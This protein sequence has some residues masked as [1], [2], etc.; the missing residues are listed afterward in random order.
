MYNTDARTAIDPEI[1]EN[2]I[3][4]DNLFGSKNST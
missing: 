3:I 1:I 4:L 2:S